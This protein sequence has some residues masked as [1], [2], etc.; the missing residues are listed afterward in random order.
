M[1]PVHETAPGEID[2]VRLHRLMTAYLAS[3]ALFSAIE[4]GVFDAL[5][6]G[7]VTA[8]ELGERIGLAGRPAAACCLPY[9]GKS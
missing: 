7:P 6:K 1:A 8:E 5:E 3:K 9:S 4:L 2:A